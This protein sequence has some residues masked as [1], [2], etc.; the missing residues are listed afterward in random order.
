MATYSSLPI[1]SFRTSPADY[2][3]L[4]ALRDKLEAQR[5]GRRMNTTEV[6]REALSLAV[7]A[8]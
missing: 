2:A 7:K 4:I 1:T 3:N 5:G 6:I 8:D